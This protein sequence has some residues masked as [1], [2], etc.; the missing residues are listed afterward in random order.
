MRFIDDLSS[1]FAP[2]SVSRHA[3]AKSDTIFILA[4]SIIML[5][6][7]LRLRFFFLSEPI[8][9][10]QPGREEEDVLGGVRAQQ[11]GHLGS[12]QGSAAVLPAGHL[13]G[14][15]GTHVAHVA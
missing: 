15:F 12:G 7:D 6:T 11:P 14:P 2:N 5:N 13:R 9:E 4:F 10:A 8:S 3:E 1:F